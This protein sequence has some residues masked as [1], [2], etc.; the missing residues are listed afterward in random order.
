MSPEQADGEPLDARSDLFALGIVL[1]EMVTGRRLFKTPTD[2][3]TLK[4]VRNAEVPLPSTH[5]TH[6]NP[7]FE[8]LVMR[9]L[10]KDPKDRFESGKALADAL[11][12]HIGPE[13][14]ETRR[15]LSVFLQEL[16]EAER[17]ADR[18]KLD[19]ATDHALHLHERQ[20]FKTL[21]GL[22]RTIG[23]LLN[24]RPTEPSRGMEPALVLGVLLMATL[25][26]ALS[27]FSP[28]M[29]STATV[30]ILV[31]PEAEL[32]IDDALRGSARKHSVR[33][34]P[35]PH[36]L[37]LKAEGYQDHAATVVLDAG[38]VF[39]IAEELVPIPPPPTP[40]VTPPY[41]V[42]KSPLE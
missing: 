31:V 29:P 42:P 4:K 2:M 24:R 28:W 32:Y 5:A 25:A 10:A 17:A 18:Q 41:K 20:G 38:D 12:L 36:V 40:V 26:W 6:L 11:A 34:E 14:D 7:E 27:P 1:W 3:Q 19:L 30:E 8:A 15:G 23:A 22:D 16:F 33:L 21:W 13:E 9:L 37:R 35:G 39:G